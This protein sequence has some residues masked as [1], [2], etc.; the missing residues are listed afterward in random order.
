MTSRTVMRAP[1]LAL[2]LALAASGIACTGTIGVAPGGAAGNRGGADASGGNGGPTVVKFT[3]D[4]S[5]APPVIPL[6]RLSHNQYR[7]TIIDLVAFATPADALTLAATLESSFA[8]LPADSRIGPDA[9]FARFFR[10]DQAVQ[11]AHIDG[12]FAVAREVAAALTAS[13]ARIKTVI[14]ACATDADAGNDGACL[15]T[16]IARFGE[17]ALRRPIMTDDVT[18]YRK[19]AG[20]PP[21]DAADYADVIALLLSAPDLMYLVEHGDDAAP[22]GTRVPLS[23]YELA[24]QL[25]Y[26]FWQT[27]PDAALLDAA[28]TGALMTQAGYQAQVDRVLADPRTARAMAEFFGQWLENIA[29]EPLDSRAGT[30]VFDALAGSF[31]PGPDLRA[32]MLDEVTDSALYY[33][34][35]GG[36]F[37]D[38]IGSKKSF[39]RTADLATL[40]GVPVWDGNGEPPSFT[41][42]ARVGLLTRAAF[43]ATGSANT[44]P[45]MKGVFIRKALL[46]DTIPPP[47]GNAAANPPPLSKESSTRQ[48]V[49]SLTGAG[50]CA[51]CHTTVINPLGFA[52]ENFDALGR[53]RTAQTLYDDVTGH[54]LGSV[55]VDTRTIPAI[56]EGDTRMSAGAGDL[57][58]MI[59]E[60]AKLNACF[61]RQ[62]FRFTFGRVESDAVDGCALGAIMDTVDQGQPLTSALRAM[63]LH[64]SF[65]QRSFR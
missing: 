45:I 11:Q 39:A 49:E 1:A 46:C 2:V 42:D 62:Y 56:D 29:L 33:L 8:Q 20:A 48:V 52:T 58:R 17:R 59:Q 10:L 24:S 28:R 53:T 40:Y 34:A 36:T 63:A 4:A 35:G 25:S 31:K 22:G 19:P 41:D 32:R 14:G 15:D 38:V 23:A 9:K 61:A 21:F 43:L 26:Q 7:N 12:G 65:R 13:A 16:F 60:S 54:V 37:A 47:P 55:P 57:T 44:R 5:L 3:C 27:M 6:R 30:P 64:D 50:I 18:F 51:G